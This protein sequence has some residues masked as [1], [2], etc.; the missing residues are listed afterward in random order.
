MGRI[1]KGKMVPATEVPSGLEWKP[2]PDFLRQSAEEMTTEQQ[3]AWLSV[4]GREF[5]RKGAKHLRYSVD[6]E[7][8]IRLVEGWYEHPGSEGEPRWQEV[9]GT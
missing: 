6:P 4:V 1:S 7:R 3:G 2:V 5:Q 9:A 8:G